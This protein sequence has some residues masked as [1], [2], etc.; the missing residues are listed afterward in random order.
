MPVSPPIISIVGRPNVGKSTLFN[1]LIGKRDAIVDSTEGVT[2]DRKYGSA[3]WSGKE[4]ILID[5][6]GYDA[7]TDDKILVSVK[8]QALVALEESELILF[9]VD[10]NTGITT[11]DDDISKIMQKQSKKVL[12]VANKA[13]ETENEANLY[14][15]MKLGLG[16]PI[17][18]SAESGRRTGDLL[19]LMLDHLPKEKT[20]SDSIHDSIS[21][22]VVGVP[23]VGKSSLVNKLLNKERQIV[24]DIPGTTRDSADSLLTYNDQ[25]YTLI[26]TAGL[27]KRAK[28]KESVEF[29]STVRAKRAIDR[30]DVVLAM[31]DATRGLDKQDI[32]IMN[33]AISKN[34]CLVCTVN[35]WDLVEKET[36]T[37]KEWAIEFR[38]TFPLL[39][40]YPILFIS[41]LEGKKIHR[42]LDKVNEVFKES[43]KRLKTSS[44]NEWLKNLVET[45]SPPAYKGKFIKISFINQTQS[46]RPTFVIFTNEPKGIKDNY[47]RFLESSLREK[48]GY[49]GV[50]ITLLFRAKS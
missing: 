36:N 1:R 26:D 22:A 10:I 49:F 7:R 33:E 38:D 21:I 40:H 13:D 47:K 5:T 19:D 17:P 23:N 27:R 31:L 48:F 18:I 8:E 34:K 43:Q 45:T 9:I 41:A 39:E 25:L 28:V 16:E 12:L 6:G 50:P 44:L 46:S 37:Q 24:T 15:F 3:S 20:P 42:V 30:S 4:F 14:D 11:G 2:R 32:N 29:Y 35:K